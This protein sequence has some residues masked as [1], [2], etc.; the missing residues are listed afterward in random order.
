[1]LQ[2]TLRQASLA[3][4]ASN[5]SRYG[6]EPVPRVPG[7][8]EYLHGHGEHETAEDTSG[9]VAVKVV[10]MPALFHAGCRS[11]GVEIGEWGLRFRAL[12]VPDAEKIDI[13]HGGHNYTVT[14]MEQ[15]LNRYSS[16]HRIKRDALPVLTYNLPPTP[17]P[18]SHPLL[19]TSHRAIST[20]TTIEES[21]SDLFSRSQ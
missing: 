14:K 1:M 8:L 19:N 17:P 20:L 4:N 9:T 5:A 18:R 6:I 10:E 15:L 13:G 3:S 2:T 7:L 11:G 16:R 21:T 12:C